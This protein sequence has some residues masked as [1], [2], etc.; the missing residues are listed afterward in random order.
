MI[1]FYL[2]LIASSFIILQKLNGSGR[3]HSSIEVER[4]PTDAALTGTGLGKS[5]S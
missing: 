5:A 1:N 4:Q 2:L 3:I